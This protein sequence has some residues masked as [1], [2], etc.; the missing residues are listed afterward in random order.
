MADHQGTSRCT[1]RNSSDCCTQPFGVHP[2]RPKEARVGS[3]GDRVVSMGVERVDRVVSKGS[4]KAEYVGSRDVWLVTGKVPDLRVLLSF[5]SLCEN[6]II[7][8]YKVII[9]FYVIVDYWNIFLSEKVNFKIKWL[10]YIS[11]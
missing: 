7:Q 3:R 4:W 5:L 9:K 10:N 11:V 2:P 1:C 8:F 6:V